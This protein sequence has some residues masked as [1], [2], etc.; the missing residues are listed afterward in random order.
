ML[1]I[2]LRA[3]TIAISV[4]IAATG[5]APA[6]DNRPAPGQVVDPVVVRIGDRDIKLSEI[7]AFQATLPA[8]YQ[9]MPMDRLFA[10][11]RR[12]LVDTILIE[13]A[14]QAA[15]IDRE[16][17]VA[18]KLAAAKRSALRSIYVARLIEAAVTEDAMRKAYEGLKARGAGQSQIRASHILVK[19]ERAANAVISELAKPG[20]DF[21]ALARKRSTGPSGAKG[22]DLGFF[23]RADMVRPFADAAFA[24]EPGAVT[25]KPVRTQFGWHVIKLVERRP[26]SVPGFE[27]AEAELRNEV[28]QRAIAALVQELR[29]KTAIE[30]Y[31]MDGSPELP[32]GI[33]LAP[34]Q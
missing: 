27:E 18:S 3:C 22:G 14:A 16:P 10:L 21:A 13:R 17:D 32:S 1:K 24:L 12:Q 11:L 25:Q 2:S 19:T 29:S 28:A 9:Q 34:R 26:V 4:A 6:Q 20:A 15:G 23:S 33:R 31:K 30:R 7:A 5:P 8:K